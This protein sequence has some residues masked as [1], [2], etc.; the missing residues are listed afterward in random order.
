MDALSAIMFAIVTT[1]LCLAVPRMYADW[2]FFKEQEREGAVDV[3]ARLLACQ[4]RW[5]QRHF[6]PAVLGV[7]MVML[8]EATS[9][10]EHSPH[11]SQVTAVY[12]ALSLTLAFVESLFAQKIAAVLMGARRRLEN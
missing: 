4:N 7:G 1:L 2:L 10:V 3:L 8:I 11:L 12:A 6:W 5:V 9:L